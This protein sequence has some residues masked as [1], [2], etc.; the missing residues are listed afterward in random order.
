MTPYGL[1]L[2]SAEKLLENLSS[3]IDSQL[4]ST[5]QDGMGRRFSTRFSI[6][7]R[8]VTDFCQWMVFCVFS[9]K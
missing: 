6:L 7:H 9:G 2:K 4:F 5:L 3:H 1:T 8:S